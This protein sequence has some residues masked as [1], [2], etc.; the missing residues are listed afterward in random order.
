MGGKTMSDAREELR[1]LRRDV[2]RVKERLPAGGSKRGRQPGLGDVL[3][4]QVR[5]ARTK[6]GESVAFGVARVAVY[7]DTLGGAATSDHTGIWTGPIRELPSEEQLRASAAVLA[8][9]PLQMRVMHRL[10]SPLYDGQPMQ[11][12]KAALAEAVGVDEAT[13]E[14]ELAPLVTKKTLRHFKT[15]QG[16][17]AYELKRWDLFL[18]QLSLAG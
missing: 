16:E 18:M 10:F 6:S 7:A 12:T 15:T 14:R 13:L 8:H 9:T 11:M 5:E 17:E 2:D 3:E 4:A 1:G